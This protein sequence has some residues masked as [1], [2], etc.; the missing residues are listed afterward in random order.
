MA[1]KV[2]AGWILENSTGTVGIIQEFDITYEGDTEDISGLGDVENDIVRRKGVPVDVGAT[3]TFS[4]K[5]DEDAD[6]YATFRTAMKQRTADTTLTFK[7][8]TDGYDYTGHAESYNE[9]ASRS[10]GVWNF[11][12]T[13][14][15]NSESAVS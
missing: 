3:I 15:V 5:I 11:S 12:C 9:T 7:K 14:Y 13:F 4:G 6:G 8:G 2:T 1:E 10:E